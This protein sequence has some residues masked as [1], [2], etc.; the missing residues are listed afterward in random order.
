MDSTTTSLTARLFRAASANGK[1][2]IVTERPV[3]AEAAEA[4]LDD[5]DHCMAS[6][7]PGHHCGRP[8]VVGGT[9]CGGHAA[10]FG[11]TPRARR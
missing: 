10:M 5:G 8:V 2:P 6:I 9:M 4:P 11:G 1:H 3:D 7:A